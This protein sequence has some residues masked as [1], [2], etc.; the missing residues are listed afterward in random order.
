MDNEALFNNNVFFVQIPLNSTSFLMPSKQIYNCK[1]KIHYGHLHDQHTICYA[2]CK[3]SFIIT[4][5]SLLQIFNLAYLF[6][7]PSPYLPQWFSHSNP[8]IRIAT[9][10]WNQV[11]HIERFPNVFGEHYMLKN[12]CPKKENECLDIW[13]KKCLDIATNYELKHRWCKNNNIMFSIV[14]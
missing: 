11:K 2:I 9:T 1:D 3:R 13:N 7:Q 6:G 4:S 5:S 12:T 14:T 8:Y 10:I